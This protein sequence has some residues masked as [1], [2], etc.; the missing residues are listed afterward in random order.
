MKYNH[1]SIDERL[2]YVQNLLNSAVES[3]EVSYLL[4][5][6]GIGDGKLLQG[7]FLLDTARRAV[8]AH[9]KHSVSESIEADDK[10]SDRLSIRAHCDDLFI[11]AREVIK[12]NHDL[13][14]HLKLSKDPR[15][16]WTGWKKDITAV[17]NLILASNEA[18]SILNQFAYTKDDVIYLVKK[19]DEIDSHQSNTN[20]NH[21]TTRI[22]DA[23][24]DELDEWVN[25]FHTVAPIALRSNPQWLEQFGIEKGK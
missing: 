9:M 2:I 17:L 7:G 23:R 15:K 22:R 6:R 8:E 11:I 10:C 19:L 20:D 12:N 4:A 1:L 25:I 5:C 14:A 13:Y 18:L 21:E 24:I 16:S 3:P